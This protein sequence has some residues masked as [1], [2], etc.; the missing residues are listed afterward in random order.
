MFYSQHVTIFLSFIMQRVMYK[1]NYMEDF[2]SL[3]KKETKIRKAW[4]YRKVVSYDEH[5]FVLQHD[6]IES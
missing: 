2:F 4:L 6:N 5:S 1:H 3:K